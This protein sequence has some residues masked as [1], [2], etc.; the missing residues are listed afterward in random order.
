MHRQEE[1][2]PQSEKVVR[3]GKHTLTSIHFKTLLTLLYFI[4]FVVCTILIGK[5]KEEKERKITSA[6]GA[7][8]RTMYQFFQF[9]SIQS[10][11]RRIP[12]K[13]RAISAKINY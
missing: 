9:N 2:V 1:E 11:F 8:N 10:Y 3:K 4:E 6:A 7:E 13:V 5:R 12:L